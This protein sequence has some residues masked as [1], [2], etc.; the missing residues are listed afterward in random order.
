VT[1][2]TNLR[3]FYFYTQGC[4]RIERPAF[5]APSE[6]R[7]AQFWNNPDGLPSRDVQSCPAKAGHPVFQKPLAR[8]RLSLEYWIARS[9]RAMTPSCCLKCEDEI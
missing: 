3:V 8:L 9:S 1:V 6:S 5:P 4:G 2:V 7:W